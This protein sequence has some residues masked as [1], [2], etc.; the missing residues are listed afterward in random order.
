MKNLT[1]LKDRI[2]AR[3]ITKEF[4]DGGIVLP[5]CAGN[6][7]PNRLADVLYV[8]SEVKDVKPFDRVV[9]DFRGGWVQLDDELLISA[10]EENV[11][12]VLED[13]V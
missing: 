12:A 8:G 10:R 7:D 2:I 9:L 6:T 1:L 13:G 4:S 5:Q 11:L 3:L